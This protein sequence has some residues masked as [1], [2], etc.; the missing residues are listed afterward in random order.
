MKMNTSSF[1]ITAD[2]LRSERTWQIQHG[3]QDLMDG[4]MSSQEATRAV[5]KEVAR[6]NAEIAKLEGSR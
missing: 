5:E 1:E 6:L 3:R 2:D 4:G